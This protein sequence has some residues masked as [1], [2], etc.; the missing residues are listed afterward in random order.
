MNNW[1]E[2]IDLNEIAQA[3]K[4]GREVQFPVGESWQQAQFDDPFD[5][6]LL[7]PH[8]VEVKPCT[9]TD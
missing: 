3:F 7:I 9:V 6:F 1:K 8:R 4:D 5:S 2:T